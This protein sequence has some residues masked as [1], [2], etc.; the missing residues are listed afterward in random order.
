MNEDNQTYQET[1]IESWNEAK[2]FFEE[3]DIHFIFRGH[4]DAKW[5]L[6]TSIER[7]HFFAKSYHVEHDF[8]KDFQRGAFTFADNTTLPRPDDYLSWLALMQHHGAPTRLL[9]FTYS[10]YI[11]CFFAFEQAEQDCAVWALEAEHLKEDL[12]H[13]YPEGFK[14]HEDIHFDIKDEVFNSIYLENKISCVFPVKPSVTNK[15]YIL[16]QSIFV[17]LGNTNETFAEQL[18]KYTWPQFLKEHIIKVVLPFSIKD[19]ALYDLNRMNINRATLFPDL[20]GYSAYLK[21]YYDLRHKGAHW[22]ITDHARARKKSID[23]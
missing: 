11:A 1:R 22:Q 8:V 5:F 14:Y 12:S 9:D 17:S 2:S 18:E 19:E 16:Q 13:K 21:N 6:K 4:S 10:P 7:C 3:V 20:D 23:P 15:R